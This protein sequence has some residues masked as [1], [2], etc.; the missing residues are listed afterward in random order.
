M[1]YT[2]LFCLSVGPISQAIGCEDRLRNDLDCVLALPRLCRVGRQTLLQLQLLHRLHWLHESSRADI[3][4]RRSGF[5]MPQWN[6]SDVLLTLPARR[7]C[8]EISVD[9]TACPPYTAVNSSVIEHFQS[10]LLVPG[11]L[12]RAMSRTSTPSLPVFCSRLKT[13]LV[14]C[15][16]PRLL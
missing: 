12:C 14:G 8:D 7:R 6:G 15:S 9:I 3:E 1:Y 4:T 11:T 10:P 16:Y 13:Q 2:V 5:R